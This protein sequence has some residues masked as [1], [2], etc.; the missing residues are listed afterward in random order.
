MKKSF[1]DPPIRDD[2]LDQMRAMA[3]RGTTVREL[4]R[5]VQER[6]GC[7]EFACVPVLAYMTKAFGLHLQEILPIR[8][9]IGSADDKAINASVM[10]AIE[11]NRQYWLPLITREMAV[12][13]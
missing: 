10:P 4:V 5:F 1:E 3:R 13:E 2:I 7:D 11:R 6:L 12:P 8:E 9:W